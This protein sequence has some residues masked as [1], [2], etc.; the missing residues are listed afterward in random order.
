[1]AFDDFPPDDRPICAEHLCPMLEIDGE[2][3]CVL[4]WTE[5][6]LGQKQITDVIPG[7]DGGI[8][9]LVFDDGH[10]IDLLCPDCG[11]PLTP[12][13]MDE[14]YDV[15]TFLDEASGLY[16]VMIAYAEPLP[17]EDEFEEE[18]PEHL[19]LC[20]WEEPEVPFDLEDETAWEQLYQLPVHIESVRTIGCPALA[21]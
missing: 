13:H 11:G 12:E 18:D 19:V 8:A 10:T 1:M 15:D 7:L 9:G 16:L 6:H 2:L 3:E 17:A 14:G 21:E 4:G 5:E 20:F